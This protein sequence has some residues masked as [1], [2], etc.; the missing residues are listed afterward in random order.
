[1]VHAYAGVKKEKKKRTKYRL[2]YNTVCWQETNTWHLLVLS[3]CGLKRSAAEHLQFWHSLT[4]ITMGSIRGA[5]SST[6]HDNCLGSG[7][8]DSAG[9]PKSLPAAQHRASSWCGAALHVACLWAGLLKQPLSN[10]HTHPG[11]L[12]PSPGPQELLSSSGVTWPKRCNWP[13]KTHLG[14]Q[15]VSFVAFLKERKKGF[16]GRNF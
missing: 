2:E 15:C 11:Y 5:C 14:H 13:T 12:P 7:A 3:T 6:P 10:Q 1:M 4:Q 9:P 16:F 8:V